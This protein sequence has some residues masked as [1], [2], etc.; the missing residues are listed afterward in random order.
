MK[1]ALFSS[2]EFSFPLIEAL[3]K[4]PHS[5]SLIVTL[6]SRAKGRGQ[7]MESNPVKLFAEK[8]RVP[9]AELETL[10][11]MDARLLF[12]KDTFDIIVVASYGKMIPE[13]IFASAK[14]AALNVHPSLLPKY[15]GAS[16]VQAALLNGD[17]KTGVSIAEITSKL[18]SGDIF[19]QEE[20]AIA[21][22]EHA[23]KL[24]KRLAQLS[25]RL[26]LQTIKN[27]EAGTIRRAPQHDALASYASKIRKE[28]GKI[29]W[30]DSARK[31]NNQIRAY[32]PWPS[33]F[34][35]FNGKRLKIIESA[36]MQDCPTDNLSAPGSILEI[37][38][39]GTISLATGNGILS[40]SRIQ[41]EG[42]AAITAKD[43]VNGQ[44][45]QTGNRLGA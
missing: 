27:F 33:A 12:A 4:S 6:P 18:D 45:I 44:R 34:T 31:I 26:L 24:S 2:S 36:V 43:F 11:N 30:H 29:N 21:I 16:P 38:K 1:I 10:K 13:D 23:D 7:K 9:C 42:H 41:L 19:S 32:S 40:V 3:V 8:H 35:F 25:A 17:P 5:L 28:D 15:R 39:S 14:T 22:N 20:T 37:H